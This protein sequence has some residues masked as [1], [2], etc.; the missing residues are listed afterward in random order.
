MLVEVSKKGG[1][2]TN[3]PKTLEFTLVMQRHKIGR[4]N[5][6]ARHFSSRRLIQVSVPSASIQRNSEALRD[7]FAHKFVLNGRIFEAVCAKDHTVY[8]LETADYDAVRS[9]LPVLDHLS[10]QGR[11]SL[12]EFMTW[13]NPTTFNKSQ[14]RKCIISCN[15]G[16]NSML[17]CRP[18]LN[19]RR[20]FPSHFQHRFR[21]VASSHTTFARFRTFTR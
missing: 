16:T 20:A 12:A 7:F 1:F 6:V 10:N 19:G 17:S 5:R 3:K 13:H 9:N 2:T 11:M 21:H 18:S 15:F 14:V 8:L 4:S